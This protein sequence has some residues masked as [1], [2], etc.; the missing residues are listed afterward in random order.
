[1]LKKL[2]SLLNKKEKRFFT[3]LLIPMTLTALTNTFGILLISPFIALTLS[4][5][6]IYT[7]PQI[8]WLYHVLHFSSSKSFLIF[9]GGLALL[10]LTLGNIA[11]YIVIKL[12][13]RG[14][15]T[16]HTNLATTFLTD[17][18]NQS[19][20]KLSLRNNANINKQVLHDTFTVAENIIKPGLSAI[21]LG[22]TAITL[23]TLI[24]AINPVI[25]IAISL[26]FCTSYTMI[27][28]ILTYKQKK[29]HQDLSRYQSKRFQLCEDIFS[30]VKLIK[31]K[32]KTEHFI[33]QFHHET[34]QTSNMLAKLSTSAQTPRF[35][36]EILAFGTV[37]T[38]ILYQLHLNMP[39]HKT[40][41]ELAV[42]VFAGYRLLPALQQVY[43]SYVQIKGHQSSLLALYEEKRKLKNRFT[44]PTNIPKN[45]LPFSQEILLKNL[46]FTYESAEG[47]T[48]TLSNINLSIQKNT[49]IG[50]IGKTG[51]GK[52]TL[53]DLILQLIT[54][55][56]G[57]ITVDDILLNT[58]TLTAWQK[59]IGYAPNPVH[60]YNASI[61]QNI[62]F[63]L[64]EDDINTT[65]LIEATKKA[66]IHD[67]IMSLPLQY[68]TIVGD[69]GA[70][71]SAGQIQ[72][73]GIARALYENPSILV[74]DEPTSNLDNQTEMSIMNSI[75]E[76]KRSKTIIMVSHRPSTLSC[77]DK[78]YKIEG[79]TLKIMSSDDLKPGVEIPIL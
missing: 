63:T 35:L 56:A 47:K 44:Q 40:I 21:S 18:I 54:Q 26:F 16:V 78:I 42:Y 43:A 10:M 58:E 19:Y 17:Y 33:H 5:K 37:I 7:H 39:S 64:V 22:I 57:T 34:R 62:A 48:T 75:K 60:L 8:L 36:L 41:A 67:T 27:Y 53:I 1:M 70:C 14:I 20:E 68:Q 79:H 2:L 71:L 76:F 72:R 31:L 52:T 11:N 25:G 73:I 59:M 30:D 69:K 24:I 45:T 61:A 3:F 74:L 55:Q 46:H 4:P 50:I 29:S 65:Q 49:C 28:K 51:A 15:Y 32:H 77:C 9:F 66:A 6:Q 23:V 13:D 38:L 12:I